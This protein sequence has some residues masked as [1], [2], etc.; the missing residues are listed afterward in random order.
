MHE[1]TRLAYLEAMGVDAYVSRH[2]LAGAAP[3]HRLVP[4][5][6]ANAGP[7]ATAP[8]RPAMPSADPAP[9]A[10]EKP[11]QEPPPAKPAA[12]AVS[13]ANRFRLAAVVAGGVLWLE[14]LGDLPLA[15]EQV[16]LIDAMSRA[17]ALATARA[18]AA[19]PPAADWQAPEPGQFDWPLHN[20][21]Q[22]D[23]G[24]E[25]AQAAV[26]AYVARR[27][28]ECR[29]R[30]IVLLGETARSRLPQGALP[31]PGVVTHTTAEVL[32]APALKA[33]VWRALAPLVG[34]R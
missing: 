12:A 30:A 7:A 24:E 27:I 33:T 32:S 3:T 2:Q 9:L 31:V 22:F 19:G 17:L 26:Q 18:G 16:Q 5:A 21:E 13:A 34:G 4:V 1:L 23:H 25:A 6:P 11:A 15:R 14:D 10:R 29:C 8:E 20:N 28:E